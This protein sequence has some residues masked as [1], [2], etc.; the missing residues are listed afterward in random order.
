MNEQTYQPDYL[1][2]FE[3]EFWADRYVSQM[4]RQARHYY[5]ALLQAGL[6][7]STRPYLPTDSEELRI[8]A[9]ADPNDWQTHESAVLHKFTK[10]TIDGVELW[11]HKRLLGEWERHL[12]I[13]QANSKKGS[14]RRPVNG[15]STAVEQQLTPVNYETVRN[16]T[17]RNETK[18]KM[19]NTSSPV[20]M[21]PDPS[22]FSDQEQEASNFKTKS[23]PTPESNPPVREI[24]RFDPF[25]V[26]PW[27]GWTEAQIK[28]VVEYHWNE[29]QDSWW[30]DHTQTEAY[31]KRNFQK[32]ADGM[33]VRGKAKSKVPA[34]WAI[35]DGQPAYRKEKIEW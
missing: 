4:P 3:T 19:K 24:K 18:T 22:Y 2:W 9:D 14:W 13:A 27:G 7:C 32:M 25:A 16:E 30:R 1:M 8:L 5:R 21:S 17:V 20:V 11:S 26:K 29:L 10:V 33:S 15:R 28:T 34:G 31:F 35:A 12:K 6:F 23:N